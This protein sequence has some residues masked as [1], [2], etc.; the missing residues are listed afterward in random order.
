[1]THAQKKLPELKQSIEDC[2]WCAAQR[3]P[4]LEDSLKSAFQ[5]SSEMV[6]IWV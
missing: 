3:V 5:K 4:S 2:V 6:R 1:M